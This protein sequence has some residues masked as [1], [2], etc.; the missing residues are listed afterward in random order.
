MD[1]SDIQLGSR[2]KH[3]SIHF[4]EISGLQGFRGNHENFQGRDNKKKIYTTND[5][6][7]IS[8]K[9]EAQRQ[10]KMLSNLNGKMI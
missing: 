7:L 10:W 8:P 9:L 3:I 4:S 6:K 5:I 2:I 1:L